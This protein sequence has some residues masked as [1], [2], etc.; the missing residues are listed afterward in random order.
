MMASSRFTWTSYWKCSYCG[1][2]LSFQKIP[3]LVLDC[4]RCKKDHELC[5]ECANFLIDSGYVSMNISAPEGLGL[6][7]CPTAELRMMLTL[8]MEKKPKKK[9]DPIPF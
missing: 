4:L 1:G 5:E 2:Y 8:M 6:R 3:K 7:E 9:D